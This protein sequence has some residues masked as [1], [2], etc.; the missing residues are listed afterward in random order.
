MKNKNLTNKNSTVKVAIVCAAIGW[1]C[2]S[3]A[4]FCQAQTQPANPSGLSPDL[5]EVVKLSQEQM[6][7]DV[8]TNYIKNSGKTY[9]LTADDLIYLK[10]Q[11]VSQGVISALEQTANDGTGQNS[12]P[13]N[14]PSLSPNLNSGLIACYPFNGDANNASGNGV[15]ELYTIRRHLLLGRFPAPKQFILL[16]RASLAPVGNMS[17]FLQLNFLATMPSQFHCGQTFK[18]R[19]QLMQERW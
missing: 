4:N 13:T 10:D 3:A 7:D 15:M 17:P 6:S 8:I 2:W 18:A 5:Q 12:S 11:K 14:F 9:T 19:A 1:I 16:D